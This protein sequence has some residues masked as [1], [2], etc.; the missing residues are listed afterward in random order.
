MKSKRIVYL[1][2]GFVFLSAC[3][4]ESLR[5]EYANQ[6]SKIDSY[7]SSQLE[8]NPDMRVEYYDGIARVILTEGEGDELQ[9]DGAVAFLYAGYNF[10]KGNMDNSSL[11]ATNSEDIASNAGWSLS[12]TTL[13]TPVRVDF[14]KE[15]LIEGLQKGLSG[16]RSGEE[17]IVLFSGKYAFGKR[18]IGTIPANAPL[19]YH[20][21]IIEIENK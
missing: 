20:F 17:C 12:D 8:S 14:S 4:S 16:T 18:N 1:L 9:K 5:L 13:F 19:A 7:I 10:S 21:W 11:F 2:I 3:T 6:D 15:T